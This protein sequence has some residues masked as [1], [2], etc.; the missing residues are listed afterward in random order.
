[1]ARRYDPLTVDL[2]RVQN[3]HA[4]CRSPSRFLL[5]TLKVVTLELGNKPATESEAEPVSWLF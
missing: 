1:M 5:H 3:L 2:L 4:V